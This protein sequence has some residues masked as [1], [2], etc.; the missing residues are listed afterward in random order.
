MFVAANMDSVK[1]GLGLTSSK[2]IN[3][4]TSREYEQYNLNS[5]RNY[6]KYMANTQYQ[7]AV[8][9]LKAA[10]LNPWLAVQSS[11]NGSDGSFSG[12]GGSTS[13]S[14]SSSTSTS[15]SAVYAALLAF[16]VSAIKL[17]A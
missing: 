7:R 9:D 3:D 8:E 10:G 6:D 14:T 4:M 17:A 12:Y 16:I 1:A 13:S 15:K 11:L 2:S 5:A